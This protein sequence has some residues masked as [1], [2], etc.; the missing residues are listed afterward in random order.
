[1]PKKTSDEDVQKMIQLHNEGK[2]NKEIAKILGCSQ[3]NVSYWLRKNGLTVIHSPEIDASAKCRTCRY[4]DCNG[5]CN[6]LLLTQKRR[7]RGEDGECLSFERGE[8][9]KIE[10]DLFANESTHIKR[11]DLYTQAII[12]ETLGE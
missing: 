4:G 2:M 5:R 1:M 3:P 9:D 6:H 7:S 8:R 12:D 11:K 10:T